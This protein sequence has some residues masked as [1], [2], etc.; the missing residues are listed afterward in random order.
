MMDMTYDK[1]LETL[2]QLSAAPEKVE[3]YEKAKE[4]VER[5]RLNLLARVFLAIACEFQG[6]WLESFEQYSILY[7]FQEIYQEEVLSK[8]ELLKKME[9]TMNQAIA[10]MQSLPA[11]AQEAYRARLLAVNGPENQLDFNPYFSK[12]ELDD[13]LGLHMF[14]GKPYYIGRYDDWTGCFYNF[15]KK[16]NGTETKIEIY[17]VEKIGKEYALT[18]GFP[19]ILPVVTGAEL[20]PNQRNN[21]ELSYPE[22]GSRFSWW[23][24]SYRKYDYYRITEPVILKM[25]NEAVFARPI[26]LRHNKKKRLVLTLFWDSF[27]WKVIKE[28]SMR[29]LMPNTYEFFK[30]GVICDEFY[31][32]SEFTYPSVASYWT[33]LRSTH[34]HLLNENV[35]LAIPEDIPLLS[36]IFKDAG[37]MTAKIGGN[38]S[39]VPYYGYARGIDRF[40]YEE[41]EQNFHVQ[42]VVSEAIEHMEAFGETDLFLWLDITDLHEVAGY[43]SMPI[44]VQTSLRPE[45]E[46]IDHTGG[47]SLY[48]SP[49]PHR[50]MVYEKQLQRMDRR[51]KGLYD[52][53]R[54]NYNAEEVVVAMISDHGNGFNVD[55]GEYFMSTQ[56]TNVPLLLYGGQELRVNPEKNENENRCSEMMETID[57]LPILCKLAGIEDERLKRNDGSLPEWLGGEKKEYVFA[58]SLF[59]KRHYEAAVY[60]EEYEFYFQSATQVSNDCRI[61][62]KNG[63]YRLRDRQGK[64]FEDEAVLAR[65]IGIISEQLGDY[66]I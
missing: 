12:D 19:C 55:E 26:P 17:P 48:Q 20:P 57:F 18:E 2:A 29:K 13:Y 40:V 43:W 1:L 49:S 25:K 31:S 52:Y 11:E 21:I 39:V 46:E 56:R 51:L 9:Y 42:D 66:K 37:Y 35:H 8:E 58:Q 61:S 15:L 34:H 27:N 38:G 3:F 4:A 44:S 6:E 14:S 41:F 54:T 53:I 63:N 24:G 5:N 16:Q 62:L 30:N 50:R 47:S 32:G 60:T 36:E 22:T 59:P 10:V 23:A 64:P 33:G 45:V 28:N 7:Q 65:C